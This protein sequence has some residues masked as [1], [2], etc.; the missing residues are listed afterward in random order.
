MYWKVNKMVSM[1]HEE[2]N[3]RRE[4]NKKVKY[5]IEKTELEFG[6]LIREFTSKGWL[7]SAVREWVQIKTIERLLDANVLEEER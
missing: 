3:F 4:I 1:T 7:K 6:K 5:E 2:H